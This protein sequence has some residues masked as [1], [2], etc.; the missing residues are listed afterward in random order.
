MT[1]PRTPRLTHGAESLRDRVL[2]VVRRA[3]ADGAT[4]ADVC[5]ALGAAERSVRGQLVALATEGRLGREWVM[6]ALRWRV[7]RRAGQ[8]ALF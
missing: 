2:R 1:S 3:G 6:G 4:V 8:P 5:R 7:A